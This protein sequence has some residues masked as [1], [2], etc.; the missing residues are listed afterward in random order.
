MN[1][2]VPRIV[3]V[4]AGHRGRDAY[5][6]Y[7]ASNP[8]RGKLVAV[9]E[10]RSDRRERIA[11]AHGIPGD[12]CFN[13]WRALIGRERL[14]DAM[15]IA[16]PDREHVEAAVAAAGLGYELLLEKPAAP[17]PGELEQLA[18]AVEAAG[19]SVTIAHVLRYTPFFSAI[20]RLL[21]EGRIGRLLAIDHVEE[22]GY[23]HFA[24][25]FVRGNWRCERRSAPM[26]LA[27][28]CHDLDLLRWF[29]GAP[30]V[31]VSSFGRRGW[32]TGDNTPEGAPD[33]CTDGCP[34]EA[35]CPF[36][37]ERIYLRR[38]R[39]GADWP[40]SVVS[41][42]PSR[43]AR[44]AALRSGPYGRCVYRCDNDVVDH[45]V[46]ACEFDNGVTASLTVGA[47]SARITRRTALFGSLGELRGVMDED[48]LELVSFV[49][50]TTERIELGEVR[51]GHCGGD[52]GLLDDFSQRLGSGATA[53]SR[54][55]L[56]ESLESHRMAFAAE[57][58]RLQ[59]QV[60]ELPR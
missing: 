25:S 36:S 44:L 22:I 3:L 56:A 12:R 58:A 46:V 5:A 21:D 60:V 27:K 28:A 19:V 17:T 50:D 34:A 16:T 53:R 20:K 55:S 30:C 52:V 32:F 37:A 35:S 13:D 43:E 38:P 11:R 4:G 23:W 41:E 45:Q 15:I 31:R 47:L 40:A 6:A 29:A 2:T 1:D 18:S 24:H 33:R 26:I 54:S 49:D 9:A 39:D 57:R 7:Y 59:R 10:P 8:R 42:D 14:A 51:G 48:R